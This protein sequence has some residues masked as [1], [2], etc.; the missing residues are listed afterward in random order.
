MSD[1]LNDELLSAYLDNEVTLEERA[2]AEKALADSPE[3][4]RSFESLKQLQARLQSV[5]RLTLPADFHDRVVQ[6][7]ERRAGAREVA[8][9]SARPVGTTKWMR[10]A[11][12]AVTVAAVLVVAVIIAV[13]PQD[14]GTAENPLPGETDVVVQNP[15]P[16]ETDD[17]VQNPPLPDD[18][19][20]NPPLPDDNAIAKSE[21][22]I[23][24]PFIYVLDA[25][26][27]RQAQREGAFRKILKGVGV[28]FDPGQ[29]DVKLDAKQRKDLLDTRLAAGVDQPAAGQVNEQFDIIEMVY[30]RAT[31][32]Q[33]DE[34]YRQM[35]QHP[36]VRVVSDVAFKPEST[37]VLNSIGEQSWS[38]A[39]S[40]STAM[41]KSYAYRINV[42]IV[43]HSSRTGFL[44]KFPTPRL[45]VRVLEKDQPSRSITGF[46]LPIP[47]NFGGANQ[48]Q[49]D[50]AIVNPAN[51]PQDELNEI[52]E[53]LVILRNLD[54]DFPENAQNPAAK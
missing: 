24:L 15:L 42:G 8:A 27:T 9:F 20:Q 13:K 6:E 14:S 50:N 36:Q 51:A 28:D 18:N 48:P 5:P 22:R 39:K 21:Q 2:E 40:E 54:G 35:V 38:L 31:G 23:D 25:A 49:P 11:A 53:I 1:R 12:V 7:A 4:R 52:N 41:P 32:S 33:I 44:A 37:Q 3:A 10:F 34:I 30:M 29:P 16:G 46:D 47:L 45:D 19:V 26:F 17:V 43:L